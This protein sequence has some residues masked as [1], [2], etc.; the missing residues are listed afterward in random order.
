MLSY[1]VASIVHWT[2]TWTAGPLMCVRDLFACI[3]TQGTLVYS[4]IWRTFVESAQNLTLGKSQGGWKAWHIRVTHP[5][6]DHARS[7]L[8]LAFQSEYTCSAPLTLLVY[9]FR[10]PSV[11][12]VLPYLW[13]G[14]IDPFV[15]IYGIIK[16]W[17][18]MKWLIML[19]VLVNGGLPEKGSSRPNYPQISLKVSIT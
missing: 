4:R 9:V 13:T 1:F 6:D 19:T 3:Y 11:D 8:T 16:W 17:S 2:L 7:S 14:H 18:I 12:S 10:P 5:C 15:T